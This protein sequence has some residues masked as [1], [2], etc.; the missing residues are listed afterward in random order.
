MSDPKE[1]PAADGQIC[2]SGEQKFWK[3]R[4]IRFGGIFLVGFVF[5]FLEPSY[6][7]Q[8]AYFWIA[9]TISIIRT[10]ALWYGSANIVEYITGNYSV[11]TNPLKTFSALI[12]GLS[13]LVALV[14]FLEIRALI[15]IAKLPLTLD[16]RIL[17]YIISWLITF[18]ITSIYAASFFFLQWHEN[19]MKAEI[20]ERTSIEARYEVLRNQVNPHFLFNSFNTL[21]GMVEPSSPVSHYVQSLSDFFRYILS[22]SNKD[23]V[24][25][26]QELTFAGNYAYIQEQR[27]SGKLHFEFAI[28]AEYLQYN[29]P[30]LSLQMLLENAV[31]HNEISHENPLL[32]K[33]FINAEGLL[34]VSNPIQKK[35]SLPESSG[36]GLENIR[37]RYAWLAGKD[38]I[39]NSSDTIFVVQLP[40]L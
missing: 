20:L 33:I 3:E 35:E 11:I 10:A 13:L 21:S 28:P 4:L 8:S 29:I 25:L 39:Q 15:Y 26:E 27:F 30:P 17:F 2:Y 32:V 19:K 24:K 37:Q 38:I 22:V 16:S 6:D 36:L 31:K 5:P 23:L 7:S 40:L 34:V 18:L 14:E 1:L 12:L 9:V